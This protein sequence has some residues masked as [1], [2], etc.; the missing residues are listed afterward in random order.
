MN[1]INNE[2][3]KLELVL[4]L[5]EPTSIEKIENTLADYINKYQPENQISKYWL[6][7][8]YN[9]TFIAG[10][11]TPEDHCETAKI[12]ISKTLTLKQINDLAG[13]L[14]SKEIW[15]ENVGISSSM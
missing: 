11:D 10:K 12:K 3:P 2:R 13:Y 4:V 15:T 6:P 5:E 7:S 9:T 8:T 1:G 14:E